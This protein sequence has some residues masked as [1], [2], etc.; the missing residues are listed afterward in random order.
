MSSTGLH[1]PENQPEK[2]RE[3]NKKD[4]GTRA[5]MEQRCFN[6][7]SM[8]VYRLWYKKLLLGMIEIRKPKVQQPLPREQG[9]MLVTRSGDNPY[10]KKGERDYAV[11]SLGEC[12]LKETQA[13]LTQWPQSLGAACCSAW[14]RTKDSWETARRNLPIRHSLTL[15]YIFVVIIQLLSHVLLFE[16][17][18]T[19]AQ[20]ASLSFTISQ[21]LLKLMSIESVMPSHPL[22]S[23]SSPAFN[24]SQH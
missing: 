15:S 14:R 23:P 11:L 21:S 5:L 16:T 7:F 1:A 18:W 2:E 19:A 9:I 13:C 22:S 12:L 17:P 6:D 10:L 24:L 8:S 3:T 20:Q 4:T